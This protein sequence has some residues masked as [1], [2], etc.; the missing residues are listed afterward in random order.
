MKIFSFLLF[1]SQFF[2]LKIVRIAAPINICLIYFQ[3]GPEVLTL[4]Y[5]VFH[6]PWLENLEWFDHNWIVIF[7]FI[8][9]KYISF[10]SNTQKKNMYYSKDFLQIWNY[11]RIFALITWF[12][13]L[14]LSIIKLCCQGIERSFLTAIRKLLYSY[15][16]ID[17]TIQHLHK[18]NNFFY[19]QRENSSSNWSLHFS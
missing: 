19:F 8:F 12:K 15:A 4:L 16:L 9:Q 1:W 11:F 18:N 17:L 14:V 10:Y 6:Q 2:S 5:K 13:C 7:F 3:I